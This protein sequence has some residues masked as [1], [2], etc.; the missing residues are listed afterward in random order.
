MG[1]VKGLTSLGEGQ[2]VYFLL[3]R[4]L[5]Y[6]T[7]IEHRHWESERRR[8]D[9][10]RASIDGDESC[11]QDLMA[12]HDLVDAPPERCDVELTGHLHGSGD[13]VGRTLRR[14]LMQKPQPLLSKRGWEDEDIILPVWQGV[15]VKRSCMGSERHHNLPSIWIVS[16]CLVRSDNLTR[17][18]SRV[19]GTIVCRCDPEPLQRACSITSAR[20]TIV[21]CSNRWRSGTSTRKASRTAAITSVA[22]SECPPRSK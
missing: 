19:I 5:R 11:A 7:Q 2:A 17:C 15:P 10:H 22:S 3:P 20:R 8:N 14:Q 16:A 21:G 13:I 1:E 12:P 6:L 18:A 9:L 4:G